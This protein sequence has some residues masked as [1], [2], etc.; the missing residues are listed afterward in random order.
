MWSGE[1]AALPPNGV[2]STV[3][4]DDDAAAVAAALQLQGIDCEAAGS[5]A[6]EE[7]VTLVAQH[8]QEQVRLLIAVPGAAACSRR[9]VGSQF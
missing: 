6:A 2:P 8:V 9:L 5:A 3:D 1:A 7:G 4:D